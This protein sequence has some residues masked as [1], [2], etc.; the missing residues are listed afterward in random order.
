MPSKNSLTDVSAS[1]GQ[2][3][4]EFSNSERSQINSL[5][6]VLGTVSPAAGRIQN[7]VSQSFNAIDN[8]TQG[9]LALGVNLAN[10]LESAGITNQNTVGV[11]STSLSSSVRNKT[12]LDRFVE[13]S[14][15]DFAGSASR[16]ANISDKA[17]SEV[18]EQRQREINNRE[19]IVFPRDLVE[20]ATAYIE[21]SFEKYE[22]ANATTPG[23]VNPVKNISLP[24]PENYNQSFS[25]NYAE[26]DLNMIGDAERAIET[27]RAMVGA[28]FERDSIRN[29][30]TGLTDS[31]GAMTQRL[32]VSFLG[33][34]NDAATGLTNQL[35]GYV[36]NPHTTVFFKGVKLRDFTWTWR[37]V[38]R[39]EEEAATIRDLLKELRKNVLPTKRT[40][41]QLN[42]P[43]LLTPRIVNQNKDVNLGEFKKCHVQNMTINYSAEGASAFF[44]DGHPV[45]ISLVLT[46]QEIEVITADDD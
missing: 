38:P 13:T 19:N 25:L 31:G 28:G 29:F 11:L 36:P 43:N 7:D 5:R 23:V 39:S 44:R 42:Y 6:G 34:L 30:I 8:T 46:F 40:G 37:L 15:F 21:L 24:L 33:T 4:S 20:N 12:S 32:G 35:L 3:K 41:G 9:R 27:G 2:L 14:P 17:P 1:S 22:R 45:A 10:S 16:T 26:S 18:I